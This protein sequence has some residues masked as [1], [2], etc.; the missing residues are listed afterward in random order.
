MSHVEIIE[1]LKTVAKQCIPA[2]GVLM[3]YGSQARGDSQD[4]SDWDLL[5]LL[6]KDRINNSD[7]DDVAFPFTYFGWGINENIVPVVYT[8]QQWE[9]YS[10]TPFYKN[11]EQDRI[12]LYE[13]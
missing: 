10:Y 8:K 5:I 3:L 11:V 7:H 9:S 4:G 2:G 6:E 12:M 1:G 13:S